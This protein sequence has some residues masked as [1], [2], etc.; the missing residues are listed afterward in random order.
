MI[1]HVVRIEDREICPWSGGQT[2]TL[3]K[4]PTS[5][6]YLFRVS[7]ATIENSVTNFSSFP[8]YLRTHL[9]LEGASKLV[10]DSET[11][12]MRG[13]YPY[14]SFAGNA[15]CQ[16]EL[17]SDSARAL[18]VIYKPEV[19]VE[20]T[21]PFTAANI[22]LTCSDIKK[23]VYDIFY[24]VKYTGT[25]LTTVP[26]QIRPDETLVLMRSPGDPDFNVQIN[27]G[28]ELIHL[29]VNL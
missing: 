19:K 29:R 12:E 16:C 9:L 25:I 28:L 20:V 3:L 24:C 15:S 27:D 26:I 14:R 23:P 7:I 21:A 22:L 5:S 4:F 10:F 1:E 17:F 11:V 8:G 6:D 13:L 2:S 18:N